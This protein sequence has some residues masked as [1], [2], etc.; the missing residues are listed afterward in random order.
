MSSEPARYRV[1]DAV[2]HPKLHE[3]VGRDV[4]VKLAPMES[5]ILHLL[6]MQE[7]Q[8]LSATYIARLME[9]LWLQSV[10]P[11]AID[12][13]IRH[14]QEKMRILPGK[15]HPLRTVPGR[16]YLINQTEEPGRRDTPMA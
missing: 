9:L 2:F 15:P 7:D 1:G 16:G 6:F 10:S 3:L 5:R 11:R 12:L 13:Y 4:R 14:L 8:V